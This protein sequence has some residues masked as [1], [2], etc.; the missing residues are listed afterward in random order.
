[1]CLMPFLTRK[2]SNWELVKIGPLSLTKVCG[3]PWLAKIS[4]NFVMVAADVVDCIMVHPSIL[5]VHQS[6]PGTYGPCKVLHNLCVFSI[7]VGQDTPKGVRVP[8][9]AP[10]GVT[11]TV[12]NSLLHFLTR[13]LCLAT[14]CSSMQALSFL[15]YPEGVS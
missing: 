9:M 1:M 6:L 5:S 10:S 11:G 2:F 12:H 7:R 13:D 4:L 8:L 15:K 3:S 14:R